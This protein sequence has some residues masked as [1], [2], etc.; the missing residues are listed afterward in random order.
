VHQSYVIKG[1]ATIPIGTRTFHFA[2]RYR[3]LAFSSRYRLIIL[4][5]P[6]C[7]GKGPLHTTAFNNFYPER[8]ANLQKLVLY[9]CG[10]PRSGEIDGK[11]YY[12]RSREEIAGYREEENFVVLDVRGDLQAVDLNDVER[13]CSFIIHG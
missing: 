9:N 2:L 8:A 7:V 13:V 4:S 6:S 10:S 11:D 12:F 5:G 1:V 3:V